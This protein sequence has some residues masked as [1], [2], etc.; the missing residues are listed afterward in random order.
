MLRVIARFSMKI[1]QIDRFITSI[2]KN[3]ILS[4]GTPKSCVPA[5][6]RA[7][8][9]VASREGQMR[10]AER[11]FHRQQIQAPQLPMAVI[12]GLHQ[13]NVETGTH[14]KAVAKSLLVK[15]LCN[16]QYFLCK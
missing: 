5:S 10:V 3:G 6:S 15:E 13:E 1:D 4:A 8:K 7:G 9:A 16:I 2:K 11:E 14:A 12:F